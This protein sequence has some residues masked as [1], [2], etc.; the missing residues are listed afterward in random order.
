MIC[1]IT[2]NQVHML[3][4]AFMH[5]TTIHMSAG[6]R[7]PEIHYFMWRT[8]HKSAQDQLHETC[9]YDMNPEH[10]SCPEKDLA[11]RHLNG[12]WIWTLDKD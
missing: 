11:L 2:C 4:T 10:W 6:V 7:Y 1:S 9:L 8:S 12:E 5:K 3:L